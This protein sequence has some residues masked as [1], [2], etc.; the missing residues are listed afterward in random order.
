MIVATL[1][2]LMLVMG[3]SISTII[4]SM[5]IQPAEEKQ[6]D[7]IGPLRHRQLREGDHTRY[8][9]SRCGA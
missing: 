4:P 8:P 2:L 1:F 7:R 6:G 5:R 3:I 9:T